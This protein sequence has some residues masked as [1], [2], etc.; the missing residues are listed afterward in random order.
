MKKTILALMAFLPILGMAQERIMVVADPHVLPQSLI[1]E[2]SEEFDAMMAKQRKMLDLS[3]AA[4]IAM[5]D[6]AMKYQ[7]SLLLIPGDLTKDSEKASHEL[8]ATSLRALEEAN[9]KTF[10][11]PGNHDI[12]GNAYRYEGT[13]K[14]PVDNLSD[15]EWES[16][17]SWIYDSV[18]AKDPSSHSYVA[19]PLEG[20]SIL[21]I[22][23]AHNTAGTGWLSDETLAWILAQAESAC[24]KGNT[25]IAMCHWQ[26]LEHF[27]RQATL[28]SA[29]RL[30]NAD[31]IRDSLMHHGVRLL[32][33]G[34]FHVNGIT[35]FRDTT[36]LT[37]DSIVEIT[38]GSPITYPCPYRWLTLS[39]DRT[40][41]QV[42]TD[43]IMALATQPDLLPYS[44]EWMRIHTQN[45]IPEMTLRAWRKIDENMDKLVA[46]S[47]I[48]AATIKSVLPQTDSAKI[49]LTNKYFGSTI[50]DLY[51]V[52][53]EANEAQ[54]PESD[55]LATELYNGMDGMITEICSSN[56]LLAKMSPVFS[57][58][59]QEL[60]RP[61]VQSLVEDITLY[62]TSY[63]NRTDDLNLTLR[64]NGQNDQ[65][66]E[67]IR[68]NTADVKKII[69]DGQLFIRNGDDLYT[70]Q[71]QRL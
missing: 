1:A 52:H 59:A 64:I 25:I 14:I 33:T 58:M 44:R 32:L 60:A 68:E 63:E 65:A 28:E 18:I 4:W 71:G 56:F 7:P 34:H 39:A 15:E 16:T 48:P 61:I 46:Y 26:I 50:V 35:T 51:L 69:L 40:Q 5:M 10:V 45:M 22:D 2:G 27:D 8:V 55:S 66:I 62:G 47:G 70:P 30:E 37:N 19:E 38:T 13:Q 42:Q 17:Y 43:D 6:T 41:V 53:S 31:A 57:F 24:A 3:E 21:G 36:G 49:A 23:G 11:I 20:L 67:T 12:G 54:N 29:C 9:I